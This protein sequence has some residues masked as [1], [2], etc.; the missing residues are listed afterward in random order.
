[1]WRSGATSSIA[2]VALGRIEMRGFL[3]AAAL[4]LGV[5]GC[6]TS[7]IIPKSSGDHDRPVPPSE[8]RAELALALDL[9]PAIDC[10]ERF[11]LALYQ[12]R[13]VDLVSWD[14]NHGACA[15]RRVSIRYLSAK[16]GEAELLTRVRELAQR[17][18]PA[19]AE[20]ARPAEPASKAP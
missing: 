11:D 16:L 20:P 19:P 13:R 7:V 17:A 15:G 9:R 5:A 6:D 14:D 12:D 10:E 18:T 8:P 2:T 1:M 4:A 3:V